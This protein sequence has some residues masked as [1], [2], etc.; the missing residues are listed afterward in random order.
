MDPYSYQCYRQYF[1]DYIQKLKAQRSSQSLRRIAQRFGISPSRLSEVVNGQGH[2]SIASFSKAVESLDLASDDKMYLSALHK[3][4]T[5]KSPLDRRKASDL[6][7]E[8]RYHKLFER[9]NLDELD[10][11]W[12]H[13]TIM[14][15]LS[16][17]PYIS[18][19]QM[20]EALNLSVEVV[21]NALLKLQRISFISLEEGRYTLL[22]RHIRIPDAH[23]SPGIRNFHRAM[24]SR[25]ITAL[26]QVPSNQRFYQSNIFTLNK[27]RYGALTKK[28]TNF[29][30]EESQKDKGQD[31]QDVYCISCQL[32]PLTKTSISLDQNTA[33]ET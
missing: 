25:A 28:I 4:A 20:S 24:L 17:N 10:I 6:L 32:F 15:V 7:A 27:D 5:T 1:S 2:L 13:F 22:Q 23:H 12:H 14:F 3:E 21:E 11:D 19:D 9:V 8:L 29:L 31:S 33:L 18:L 30:S 26:N 16:V